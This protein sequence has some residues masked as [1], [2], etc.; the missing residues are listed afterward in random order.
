MIISVGEY[1]TLLSWWTIA[2]F[3][4][5]GVILFLGMYVRF[6]LLELTKLSEFFVGINNEIIS[7]SS[8]LKSIHDL[9]MFYGDETLGGLIKHSH[10][11]VDKFEEFGDVIGFDDEL[12]EGDEGDIDEEA[13]S[14]RGEE[15]QRQPETIPFQ[16][17]LFYG[18]T[19]EGDS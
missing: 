18:G 8:H 12:E 17:Q 4:L 7:F 14:E 13:E 19:R 11:L 9:E 15:K 3:A 16:P 5:L 6:L 10:H 1:S 2:T